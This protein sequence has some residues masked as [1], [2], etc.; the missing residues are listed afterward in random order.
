MVDK[1]NRYSLSDKDLHC[2]ARTLQS[3]F[4]AD[5][6][7]CFYCKYAISCKKSFESTKKI[8]F[9]E[10]W[11]KLQ[12]L[13]GVKIRLNN[14]KTKQK[15]VLAGSWIENYPEL[16]MQFTNL[17]FEEQLGKLQNQN[18]LKCVDNYCFKGSE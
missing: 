4:E 2:I 11:E 6:I 8:P 18:I 10:V 1:E 7:Q 13:T 5:T 3:E 17:S 14:P 16:F 12:K 9:L 15:D